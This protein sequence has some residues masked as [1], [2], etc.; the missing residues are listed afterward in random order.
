[1]IAEALA[2][3]SGSR[4]R[5]MFRSSSSESPSASASTESAGPSRVARASDVPLTS[6]NSAVIRAV[7]PVATML[8][9]STEA[10]L[11][12]RATA[13]ASSRPPASPW[14]RRCHSRIAVRGS[15]VRIGPTP[16]RL[17]EIR[18][19]IPSPMPSRPAPLVVNGTTAI[20]SAPLTTTRRGPAKK[21]IQA[22]PIAATRR[23]SRIASRF[24][25]RLSRV[26]RAA[27]VL[28]SATASAN[29]VIVAKRWV[30]SVA[31]ARC[32][33]PS[34]AGGTPS[35]TVERRG[36]G[37]VSIDVSIACIVGPLNACLPVT[38]S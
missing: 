12:L 15:T 29:S 18:S 20:A 26:A 25:R 33:A 30:G 32:V 37:P 28:S 2:E 22:A 8:P 5:Q 19:T 1:M 24:H 6:N 4:D 3:G 11:V 14:T 9:V 16:S 34:M 17:A 27:P 36:R 7:P 31:S 10:A 13:S 21:R 38:S 23:G 35:T